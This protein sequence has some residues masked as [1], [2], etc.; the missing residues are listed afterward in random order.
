[1]KMN[2]DF[3]KL[4]LETKK[5]YLDLIIKGQLKE[6]KEFLLT[7]SIPGL[8]IVPRDRDFQKEIQRIHD[9]IESLKITSE[10]GIRVFIPDN[11]R[12]PIQSYDWIFDI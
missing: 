12:D 10:G 3:R 9:K 5:K 11:G 8:F 2:P 6:A 4:D 7:N 1:M